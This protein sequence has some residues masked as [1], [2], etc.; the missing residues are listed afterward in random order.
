LKKVL[1]IGWE[2]VFYLELQ[3]YG[4]QQ[5]N[6]NNAEKCIDKRES[7]TIRQVELPELGKYK[8]PIK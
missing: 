3:L 6:L 1:H 4:T 2:D 7:G 8:M 5:D